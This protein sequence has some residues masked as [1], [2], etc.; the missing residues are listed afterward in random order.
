MKIV[1]GKP[2]CSIHFCLM[3]FQ[4]LSK[5]H[6]SICQCIIKASRPCT[7]LPPLLFGLGIDCDHVFGPKWLVNELFKLSFSISYSEVNRFKKSV[8][9]NQ[10]MGNSVI[11]SY[12]KVFTQFAGDNIDHSIRTLDG[13]GTF[14]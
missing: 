9:A 12:P 4:R 2:T 10:P 13:S 1:A 7:I 6:L 11:N 5:G 8:V 14:H 3:L